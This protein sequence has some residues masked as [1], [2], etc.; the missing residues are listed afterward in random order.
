[1]ITSI[2]MSIENSGRA[3][4]IEEMKECK[5]LNDFERIYNLL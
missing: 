2:K 4:L 3:D 5:K 1:M